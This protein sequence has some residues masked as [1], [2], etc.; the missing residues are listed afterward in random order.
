VGSTERG[1]LD[2]HLRDALAAV[3]HVARDAAVADL[4]SGG[5]FPGLPLAIARPDLR[6][7]LVEARERRANFLRHV[8]RS[9]QLR[10]EVRCERFELRA[11]A[12]FDVVC[13]RAV[14]PPAAVLPQ[15]VGWASER[16][17]VWLWSTL[18]ATAVGAPV[19]A[20]VDL[21]ERGQ[22]LRIAA[23]VLR[24]GAPVS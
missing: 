13:L 23:D 6:V 16:G 20:T 14:G 8:V 9:L 4:G 17:E 24:R 1:A 22:I 10:A 15:A 19:H 12:C 7:T 3:P 11:P 5:G 2:V 18:A 21:E